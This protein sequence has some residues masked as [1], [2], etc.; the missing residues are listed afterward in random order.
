MEIKR[1]EEILYE[2]NKSKFL[3]Y[4]F[5]VYNLQEVEE[6]LSDMRAKHEKATH[7]CF[8]Y[9]IS[10]PHMEKCSDDGEPDGTAGRPMLEILKKNDISNTLLIVVRYFGGIKLGAGGLVR[11]YS[12]SAKMTIDAAEKVEYGDYIQYEVSTS[13]NN[14]NA[15]NLLQN[16]LGFK[17]VSQ[18]YTTEYIATIIVENLGQEIESDF[19]LNG[20][21][22]LSKKHK[23]LVK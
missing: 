22:V 18:M 9:Q 12:T 17:I 13:I 5:P 8:A 4:A 6:I 23:K 14:K 15:L 11:A 20:I 1:C 3:G 7:V 2:I 19:N 16:K 21:R 10:S